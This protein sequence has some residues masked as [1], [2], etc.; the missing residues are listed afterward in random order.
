MPK[1]GEPLIAQ[2]PSVRPHFDTALTALLVISVAICLVSCVYFLFVVY[3]NYMHSDS[4]SNLLLAEEILRSG[5]WL[6]RGWHYVSDAVVIADG[7]QLALPF[8]KT[9]GLSSTALARTA[10]LAATL[11]ACS[12][13]LL[14]RTA[15]LR[16]PLAAAAAAFMVSGASLIYSDLILGL[17]VTMSLAQ[18]A[19]LL[20]ATHRALA[21]NHRGWSLWACGAL[22]ALCFA[23]NP[24]KALV[25][26]A[27]PLMAAM[28]ACLYGMRGT[29][30]RSDFT[31]R[32]GHLLAVIFA[33]SAAG[34]C[35]HRWLLSS[36]HVND[37]F[38]RYAPALLPEQIA[39]NLHT[40]VKLVLKF[41]GMTEDGPRGWGGLTASMHRAVTTVT[42]LTF[43]ALGTAEAFRKSERAVAVLAFYAVF[44]AMLITAALLGAE[45]IKQYYGIYYL[46]FAGVPAT[47]V[48]FRYAASLPRAARNAVVLLIIVPSLL[49][50]LRTHVIRN[51][52]YPGM[53]IKQRTNNVQKAELIAW[54]EQRGLRQGY[55]IFWEANSITV[56]TEGRIRVIPVSLDRKGWQPFRWLI[57]EHQ[58]AAVADRAPVFLALPDL[59]GMRSLAPECVSEA[60]AHRVPPY[61]VYVFRQGARACLTDIPLARDPGPG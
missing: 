54:L 10:T 28:A 8:V 26:Q 53:S 3:P 40:F 17:M 19:L 35:L 55:S 45:A 42:V 6:P 20:T 57:S 44:A 41:L 43:F 11:F 37:A 9:M 33:S 27:L 47:I 59:D 1:T 5:E 58:I 61:D 32:C 23:T 24:R 46:A 36:L 49:L 56:L 38:A 12:T 50:S 21:T 31:R 4:I 29:A 52:H 34:Y 7:A 48:A 39:D 25:F 15:D 22:L 14:A 30:D 18:L 2:E 16:A 60:E 51:P 13:Y